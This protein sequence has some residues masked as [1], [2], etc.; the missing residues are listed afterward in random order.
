M[1]TGGF[2][3]RIRVRRYYSA[4][5]WPELLG[6][7]GLVVRDFTAKSLQTERKFSA[8][9]IMTS[10]GATITQ[11]SGVA[12]RDGGPPKKRLAIHTDNVAADTAI[13]RKRK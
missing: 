6:G 12:N 13:S 9:K 4:L 10:S 11:A 8:A 5:L 7:D 2:G 1:L 3:T